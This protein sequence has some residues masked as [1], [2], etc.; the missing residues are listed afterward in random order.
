MSK[1][2]GTF[3]KART[4]L[5]HL[6]PEYLR[7]YYAAKLGRGVDDLDLNLDDFVQKVNSDLVGKVVNIASRCAGFI[8]KGNAGVLPSREFTLSR[9]APPRRMVERLPRPMHAPSR[10][11]PPMKAATLPR[12]ARNH[13][14][15][16]PGQRLD[17]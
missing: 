3:I 1:S 10:R 8:H 15:G 2:R 5:D 9:L 6:N 4:Y 12:H 13:G 11:S 17:R 14:P 16:R 7:Y